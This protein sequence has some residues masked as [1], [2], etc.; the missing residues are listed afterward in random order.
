MV[1]GWGDLTAV[2]EVAGEQWR[3]AMVL[4]GEA[5]L[6]VPMIAPGDHLDGAA[7]G[8]HPRSSRHPNPPHRT[9]EIIHQRIRLH[10]IPTCCVHRQE[11]KPPIHEFKQLAPQ[12]VSG[13]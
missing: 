3:E 4:P 1:S 12:K 9:H 5:H 2:T 7:W 8:N 10:G 11:L 13:T 6:Q